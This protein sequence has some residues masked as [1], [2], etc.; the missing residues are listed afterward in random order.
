VIGCLIAAVSFYL[1]V[2]DMAHEAVPVLA[3]V[4][5][6]VYI[7]SFSAG[8]GAMPWVVM[9]EVNSIPEGQLLAVVVVT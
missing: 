7:G 1:K 9:S 5:I 3:V 6:M 4:G 2:H 8:M